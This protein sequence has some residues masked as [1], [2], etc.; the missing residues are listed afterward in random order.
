LARHVPTNQAPQPSSHSAY[1]ARTRT[2]E[3]F[4]KRPAL[5]VVPRIEPVPVQTKAFP[6]LPWFPAAFMSSTRGWT[7]TARGIYRELLDCQWEMG[8]LPANT[9]A[10]QRLIQ[11][12]A[13]EWRSWSVVLERKFPVG[14]DGLR[15]NLT[16]E[17]HRSK[18]L[19]LNARH[20]RGAEATNAKRWG[21]RVDPNDNAGDS[22]DF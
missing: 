22:D 20:R 21:S 2:G 17:K 16:L 7:V 9:A 12:T 1:G 6:M 11:A 4:M 18:S 10:L 15:R 3:A 14:P 19:E 13:K 8:S 5:S